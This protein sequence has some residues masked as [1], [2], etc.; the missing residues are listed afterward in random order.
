MPARQLLQVPQHCHLESHRHQAVDDAGGRDPAL[1][2]PALPEPLPSPPICWPGA[3]DIVQNPL[4]RWHVYKSGGVLPSF[5]P[6]HR[7]SQP[8]PMD[9]LVP[10]HPHPPLGVQGGCSSPGVQE[11]GQPQAVELVGD[12]W[13]EEGQEA[14]DL[15]QAVHLQRQAGLGG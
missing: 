12:L 15:V 9:T 5:L 14:A 7:G 4:H 2:T 1:E 6:S 8:I 11:Q 3:R 10:S 13:V